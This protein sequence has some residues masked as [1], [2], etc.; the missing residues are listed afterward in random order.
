MEAWPEKAPLDQAQ[1][2]T[3]CA[4][5]YVALVDP[6]LLPPGRY[7]TLDALSARCEARAE[8][9]A[10]YPADYVVPRGT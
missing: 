4:L 10:T 3:A 2:T 7:P 1:I 9:A 5:R 6:E 8:F